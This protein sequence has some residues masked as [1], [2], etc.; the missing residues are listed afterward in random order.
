MQKLLFPLSLVFLTH[1]CYA[2]RQ[3]TTLTRTTSDGDTS[4]TIYQTT[5]A[6]DSLIINNTA[7]Y[8]IIAASKG[9]FLIANNDTLR[10]NFLDNTYQIL[11]NSDTY[12]LYPAFYAQFK[13]AVLQRH[14]VVTL[15]QLLEDHI[16]DYPIEDALP[17]VLFTPQTTKR[18]RKAVVRTTRS[19]SDLIDV[20]KCSYIY[21]KSGQ[22]VSV[23]A[24]SE[25]EVHFNKKLKYSGNKVI[26]I[27][28][29]MDIET[30]QITDKNIIYPGNNTI[31]WHQTVLETGKNR[32]SEL[33]VTLK[34]SIK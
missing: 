14:S 9:V 12:Y 17:F 29:H 22:L 23:T 5:A 20:W 11:I 15:L 21:N 13:Q 6:G 7:I 3:V 1:C 31:K 33:S 25:E 2:Q 10:V 8:C 24:A 27:D 16:G 26:S 34:K 19:Q 28:T 32:E 4:K 30:R 18:I